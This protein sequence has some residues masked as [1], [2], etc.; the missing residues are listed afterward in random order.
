MT[1]D[2]IRVGIIGAGRMGITHHSILNSHPRARVTAVADPSPVVTALLAKYADVRSYRNS[3]ALLEN[4]ALDALLVCT[5]PNLNYDILWQALH[6]R[7]H[8]FVEKPF[9]LS[10][11]QG[12]ELAH[13]FDECGLVN[14]VGYV[15]RF[16]D[17]FAKVKEFLEEDILGGVIRFR[18]EMYSSTVVRT[19]N[20]T[21]WRASHNNGGGVVYE[22]ASHSID[23]A[24]FLFGQPTRVAG[25]CLSR[26]HSRSVEDI[27]SS[28][29]IYANG[30]VG[31]LYVNWSDESYRKPT[32]KLEIF[33]R[34]G[35]ILADQHGIK[36]YLGRD[37]EKHKLKQGWTN[38][39]ITD[40]FKNVPFYVR[41]NEFTVQLYHFV[42]RIESTSDR[43]TRCSFADGA[44]ALSVIEE[45]LR[46]AAVNQNG[47]L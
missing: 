11:S 40:L 5:P 42:D 29:F 19:Q 24:N 6:K 17:A 13:S 46:D 14:Q 47:A 36:I 33:G 38:L 31:S 43:R 37:N 30:T 39:Y 7:L 32:N 45:I 41:G 20:E 3:G 10:A 4:E 2:G 9:T 35:R 44:A 18:T 27:V 22:M 15:N 8:T 1:I 28:T 21:G 12:Y 26:V 16:N 34:G 23:L 25:S